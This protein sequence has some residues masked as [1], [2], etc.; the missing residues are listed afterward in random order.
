MPRIPVIRVTLLSALLSAA[1]TAAPPSFVVFGDSGY[2]PSYERPD[3]DEPF[4]RT[5]GDYLSLETSDWL[6]RNPD[7]RG[8][9]PTPWTFEAALDAWMPASGLHPVARAMDETCYGKAWGFMRLTLDDDALDLQVYST[10]DDLSGRPVLES[11]HRFARRSG[12]VVR[13][14]GA[15]P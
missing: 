13:P 6:E 8:F 4:P 12:F 15:G 11:T 7:L 5:L 1:A 3:P 10:P 9:K 14:L 2:I